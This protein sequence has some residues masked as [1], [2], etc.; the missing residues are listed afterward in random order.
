MMKIKI[1]DYLLGKLTIDDICE[2][3]EKRIRE[4]IENAFNNETTRRS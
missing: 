1:S 3:F 4:E 2:L